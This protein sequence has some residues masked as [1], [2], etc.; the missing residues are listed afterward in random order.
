VTNTET[1]SKAMVSSGHCKDIERNP[2]AN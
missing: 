2:S 1:V